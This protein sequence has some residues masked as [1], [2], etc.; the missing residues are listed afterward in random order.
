MADLEQ[1]AEAGRGG[2]SSSLQV[3]GV[4]SSSEWGHDVPWCA[5]RTV[6]RVSRTLWADSSLGWAG[7]DL[8]RWHARWVRAHRRRCTRRRMAFAAPEIRALKTIH[9]LS[10]SL[11][12]S[13]GGLHERSA[14]AA[15]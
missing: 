2:S 6:V 13:L 4:V 7:G 12:N 8:S 1:P 11:M 9:T 14:L 3:R 10:L 5:F 15:P